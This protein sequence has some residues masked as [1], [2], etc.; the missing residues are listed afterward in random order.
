[1]AVEEPRVAVA[2][3]GG[4]WP[5]DDPPNPGRDLDLSNPAVA[6][7]CARAL[8][9]G[10]VNF[11]EINAVWPPAF[12]PLPVPTMIAIGVARPNA[13]GQAIMRTVTAFAKAKTNDGCGPQIAHITNVKIE[14]ATTTGTKYK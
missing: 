10:A 13:Q 9:H 5:P 14:M 7:F 3:A 12:A 2:A 4:T 6:R 1:M 11:E 8:R